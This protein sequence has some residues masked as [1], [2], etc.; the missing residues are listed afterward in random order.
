M[1]LQMRLPKTKIL[2]GLAV[3]PAVLAMAWMAAVGRVEGR[4]AG[5]NP[6]WIPPIL[7]GTSAGGVTT[8]DLRL[9]SSSAAL[10]P[11]EPT[12]TYGY[13]GEGFWGPTVIMN[14]GDVVRVSL[15]NALA[16][17]TT[18]HWHGLLVPGPVDGGPHQ[19][20]AAGETWTTDEF[21]VKNNA[22][23]YWYHPHMHELTQKQ[24][25][26]GA[27]GLIIIR[28]AEEAALALPRTYGVDDIPL[29]LTSRRFNT[30]NGIANQFQFVRTAYGDYAL[31]NGTINAQVTLPKQFVR[32]RILNAE[33]ER[34]YN[35]GFSDNR[36]F[37]VIGSDGGLLGAP[38]P[39]RRLIM[40]PGERMNSWSTC[41]VTS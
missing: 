11:G 32:V 13:N 40:A 1:S 26:L 8:Y 14:T 4:Q 6:L 3:V 18:T 27:G 2:G 39:V 38:V 22:A 23:T 20:I 19:M 24:L 34:D 36:T 35:L 33:I 30:T 21:T 25:T 10:M 29:V 31:A 28:D 37:Y 7:A 16:E 41:L 12:A 15:Q 9:A 17:M 5:L